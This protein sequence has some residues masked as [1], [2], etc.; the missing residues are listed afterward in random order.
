M[1]L[2]Q[3]YA[4]GKFKFVKFNEGFNLILGKVKRPKNQNLDSHNL[5]KTTLIHVIDFLLL[6]GFNKG[7]FLYRNKIK[8]SEYIFYLEILLNDGSYLTVKRSVLN[9]SK[10]SF[11]KHTN[12]YADF[13]DSDNWDYKDI[14]FD[15]AKDILNDFLDFDILQEYDYRKTVSYFLRSQED[16]L[17]V[18]QLNKYRSSRDLEWKPVLLQLLGFDGTL[19]T[20]KYNLDETIKNIDAQIN[21]LENQSIV[22]AKELDKIKG[23]IEVKKEE[24]ETLNKQLEEFD[25]YRKE[26][27]I[28]FELVDKIESGI[29]D[30]NTFIYNLDYEA[31][32]IEESLKNQIEF[33]LEDIRT[34]YKEV[35]IYFPKELVKR[36]EDVVEFNHL[37]YEERN[38]H[39]VERSQE[40][41]KERVEV[42]KE[43]I[44]LNSKRSN[45][46]SVLQSKDTFQKFK[47]YQN[48]L[49]KIESELVML[50]ESMKKVDEI[51]SLNDKIKSLND[52]REKLKK[53]IEKNVYGGNSIYSEI[54]K[55]FNNIIKEIIN[56]PAIPSIEINNLGNVEF[57]ADIQETV[58]EE[59]TAKG[60]GTTYKKL[61]CVAFDLSILIAYANHSFFKF[62][63]HDGVLEGLDNRKKVRFIECVRNIC[64]QYDLQYIL[65]SI[66]HDL[67]RDAENRTIDF[68]PDEIALTLS[69]EGDEG[70]LFE[71]SF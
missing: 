63:Y 50:Q 26:K 17:D 6:K 61:L 27:D 60:M 62:V 56:L 10:I 53:N 3:V 65:T 35:G 54:R 36:Y 58:G 45:L 19:L 4:E 13:R 22:S 57:H 29:S 28:N 48:D 47:E 38:Q 31:G 2:S 42:E 11:K 9:N 32:K 55:T 67:P 15:K 40:I 33:N 37:L 44:D 25:F 64:K 39:L 69:D 1:K 70:R 20:D 7:Q 49:I 21:L 12:K 52:T 5:G 43:L 24:K 34:L 68:N 23:L 14:S 59:I 71:Q 30:L 41:R 8:F 46:L 16:Y 51:G 66:E 18:F